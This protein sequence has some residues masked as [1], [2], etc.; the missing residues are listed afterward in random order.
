MVRVCWLHTFLSIHCST[1]HRCH[2]LRCRDTPGCLEFLGVQAALWNY[3]GRKAPTCGWGMSTARH[4]NEYQTGRSCVW[5]RWGMLTTCWNIRW[6]TI[7]PVFF[8]PAITQTKT[9]NISPALRLPIT[10]YTMLYQLLKLCATACNIAKTL[11]TAVREKLWR[12]LFDP[13]NILS[14]YTVYSRI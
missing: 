13:T 10:N 3:A 9:S 11:R 12:S 2:I 4:V 6:L 14:L 8:T 5:R 1:R 7:R